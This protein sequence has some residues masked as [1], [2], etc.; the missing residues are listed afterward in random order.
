MGVVFDGKAQ[1][2]SFRPPK[3]YKATNQSLCSK[4]ELQG[5]VWNSGRLYNTEVANIFIRDVKGEY[6]AKMTQNIK[7]LGDLVGKELENLDDHGIPKIGD[8]GEADEEVWICSSYPFT[9][10]TTFH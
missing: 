2:Y 3:R 4:K 7:V 1:G 8:P 9:H 10:K 6:F 5:I